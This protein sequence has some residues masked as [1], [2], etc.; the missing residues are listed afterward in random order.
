M[1]QCN[2]LLSTFSGITHSHYNFPDFVGQNIQDFCHINDVQQFT[3]HQAEGEKLESNVNIIYHRVF[4]T[5]WKTLNFVLYSSRFG[6]GL[7]FDQKH[8]NLGFLR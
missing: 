6:K 8:E 7:E 4:H 2:T 3:R 5:N 1:H